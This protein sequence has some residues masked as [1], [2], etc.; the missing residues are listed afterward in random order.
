MPK[1]QSKPRIIEAEQFTGYM[2]LPFADRK[3]CNL[4]P[5]GWYV[6]T[7]HGQETAIVPGDWIVPEPDNRGFYPIKRDIFEERYEI[8][9]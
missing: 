2:P 4:G 1:F 5:D 9:R 3:A 6:V 7:A 8:I